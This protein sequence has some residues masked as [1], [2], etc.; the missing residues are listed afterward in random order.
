LAF[1]CGNARLFSL[2]HAFRALSLT[3]VK[4]FTKANSAANYFFWLR[5]LEPTIQETTDN[6]DNA[7]ADGCKSYDLKDLEF[8]Y[9]LAPNNRVLKGL[10]LKVSTLHL[11]PRSWG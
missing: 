10:S 2:S 8:S 9:P 3:V 6:I 1:S 5:D 11:L 7:P 4:G